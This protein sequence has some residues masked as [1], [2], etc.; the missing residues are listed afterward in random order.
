MVSVHTQIHEV[1]LRS[2]QNL[3]QIARIRVSLH[4]ELSSVRTTAT[5]PAANGYSLHLL[6]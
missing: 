1:A 5:R 4:C 3:L 2:G 6:T